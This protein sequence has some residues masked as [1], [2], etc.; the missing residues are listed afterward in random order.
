MYYYKEIKDGRIIS[1]RC[2]SE[3]QMIGEEITEEEYRQYIPE[4]TE[5]EAEEDFDTIDEKYSN[6]ELTK[7]QVYKFVFEGIITENEYNKIVN[8]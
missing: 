6:G 1:L 8:K 4:N 2:S 7:E 5:S 3:P